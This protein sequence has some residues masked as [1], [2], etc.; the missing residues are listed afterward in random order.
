MAY[1]TLT[2][3]AIVWTSVKTLSYLIL[4][5]LPQERRL[6]Q[7]EESFTDR[8][9]QVWASQFASNGQYQHQVL[10]TNGHKYELR[11][12][13]DREAFYST[14]EEDPNHDARLLARNQGIASVGRHHLY[15]IG[16]TR[17]SHQEIDQVC[18]ELIQD[19][20]YDPWDR[21]CQ[22]FIRSV[23]DSIVSERSLDWQYFR[24]VKHGALQNY[25][26]DWWKIK[27]PITLLNWT[28]RIVS[29]ALR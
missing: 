5:S 8:G 21:N 3:A 29:A 13:E 10:Y 23:A 16:W 22:H 2:L 26:F 18:S 11:K 20:E 4:R 9:H 7:I 24:N 15:L 28:F 27:I 12:D 14:A 19:W 17:K 25:L 6:R 1:R